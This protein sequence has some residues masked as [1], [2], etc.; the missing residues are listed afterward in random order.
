MLQLV[1]LWLLGGILGVAVIIGSAI[2]GGFVSVWLFAPPMKDG[3]ATAATLT[4]VLYFLL[5]T[6]VGAG[7]GVGLVIVV[8][9]VI[10]GAVFSNGDPMRGSPRNWGP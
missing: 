10:W 7:A 6:V 3:R 9:T 8:V 5:G 4:D 2:G 1:G